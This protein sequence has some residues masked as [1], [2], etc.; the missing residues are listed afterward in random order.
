MIV[1]PLL[2]LWIMRFKKKVFKSN[3]VWNFAFFH[4][5]LVKENWD[6]FIHEKKLKNSSCINFLKS[7]YEFLKRKRLIW[8]G[9]NG[10][11]LKSSCEKTHLFVIQFGIVWYSVCAV[12]RMKNNS[13]AET[14]FCLRF[15]FMR[16]LASDTKPATIPNQQRGSAT[17]DVIGPLIFGPIPS[18]HPNF[19]VEQSNSNV[20]FVTLSSLWPGL[21]WISM[22]CVRS[23]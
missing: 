19:V 9:E 14:R 6:S 2:Y 3:V 7:I 18:S 21:V 11:Y 12:I 16:L 17:C 5:S 15:I 22:S 1:S 4:D 20:F 13:F 10:F 8:F 23:C